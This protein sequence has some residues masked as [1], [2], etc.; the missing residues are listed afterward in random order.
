M[1]MTCHL[2]TDGN[3]ETTAE[4]RRKFLPGSSNC[5][6]GL[7][8]VKLGFY[9]GSVHS[10]HRHNPVTL[11][12]VFSTSSQQQLAKEATTPDWVAQSGQQDPSWDTVLLFLLQGLQL[13]AQC[14]RNIWTSGQEPQIPVW[15]GYA[16]IW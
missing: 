12:S 13:T 8:Q 2:R 9:L 10:A 14:G 16:I 15:A 5:A 3:R 4:L 11:S 1:P 7:G 6:A